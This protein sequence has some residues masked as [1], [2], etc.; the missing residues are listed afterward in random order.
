[1]R[2]IALIVAAVSAFA[3][4]GHA[5]ADARELRLVPI[6]HA[7]PYRASG[8][9]QS[10]GDGG[11]WLFMRAGAL[12]V[13]VFDT[14]ANRTRTLDLRGY[15]IADSDDCR[16]AAVLVIDCIQVR[17]GLLAPPGFTR[18]PDPPNLPAPGELRPG[19]R[20]PTDSSIRDGRADLF[21][22]CRAKLA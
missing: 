8:E 12:A 19:Q 15:G 10:T 1:V 13:R 14:L 6:G 11:H 5:G 3:A 7:G 9:S 17:A 4:C 21:V 16:P 20:I 22:D 2:R 18:L